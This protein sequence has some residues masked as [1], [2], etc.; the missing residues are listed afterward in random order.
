MI[1]R[2][3]HSSLRGQT[4]LNRTL[5][6]WGRLQPARDFSPACRVT[7]R[8]MPGVPCIE[9]V[10]QFR[11]AKTPAPPKQS[12]AAIGGVFRWGRRF[13]LPRE[14][15][16][17]LRSLCRT[18]AYPEEIRVESTLHAIRKLDHLNHDRA[19]VRQDRL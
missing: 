2:E 9:Q 13:R 16:S 11:Q 7:A 19:A 17:V 6:P 8:H 5:S 15:L 12:S 14:R 10:A 18:G 4:V 1:E 3:M